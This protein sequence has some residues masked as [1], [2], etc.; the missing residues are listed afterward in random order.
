M[1][2]GNVDDTTDDDAINQSINQSV[3]QS[4]KQSFCICHGQ[5]AFKET[6]HLLTFSEVDGELVAGGLTVPNVADE[7]DN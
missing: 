7:A 2:R 1:P 4:V 6:L 5:S 3:S